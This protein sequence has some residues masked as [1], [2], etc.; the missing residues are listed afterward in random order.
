MVEWLWALVITSP[1]SYEFESHKGLT[2]F[3]C[4]EA[5]SQIILPTVEAGS[6]QVNLADGVMLEVEKKCLTYILN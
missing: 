5:S 6:R 2:N 4:E 3:T 1:L